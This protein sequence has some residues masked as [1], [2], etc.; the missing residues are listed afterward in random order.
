M[1]KKEKKEEVKNLEKE[2][3]EKEHEKKKIEKNLK[4]L[5]NKINKNKEIE[6]QKNILNSGFNEKLEE[7]KIIESQLFKIGFSFFF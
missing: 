5:E 7:S 4:K 3:F 6:N 2:R 1:E